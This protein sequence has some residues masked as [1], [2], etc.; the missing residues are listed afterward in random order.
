[1]R[2]LSIALALLFLFV[3]RGFGAD[4][5]ISA[6][7]EECLSCHATATPGIVSDWKRSRHA[8][9]TPSEAVRKPKLEKRM[10]VD[11]VPESV[12]SVTIGCAECH[13]ANY[14][15]HGDSFAHNGYAVHTVVTPR[16]CAVCH[17]VE[18]S[19]YGQNI[20][21]HAYGNL[22]NNPVYRE[23]AHTINAVVS[24]D[25]SGTTLGSPD[26]QTQEDSCLACHGTVVKMT[27]LRTVDTVQGEMELPVLAGWP[28]LGV[29]RI[30]P[31]G[32]AGACTPCHSRHQFSIELA[33]KPYACQKCHSGPDVPVNKVYSVSKHGNVFAGLNKDWNFQSVP[34]VLGKDFASPTCAVCHVSLTVNEDGEVLGERTHRMNDRKAWRLFGLIYAHPQ[35]KSPDTSTIRT[36]SGLPLPTE[37][38]GEPASGYLIDAAEQQKRRETMQK[39]CLGCHSSGWVA[40]HYKRLEHSIETTNELTKTA[41]KI[42]VKAWETGAAKGIAQKDSIFN[43]GI[44]K[45][46]S[47]QWLF[48]ANSARF[49][50]AMMGADYGV[51]ESGRW[52]MTKNIQ[53]LVD[54]LNVKSKSRNP[55]LESGK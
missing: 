29:G 22:M 6:A 3:G 21:S 13:T 53:Q 24:Y 46:W 30:N 38:T 2:N 39:V 28:N 15:E 7:T 12:Y 17:P 1:M 43:E 35:P 25:D 47:A 36:E 9:V 20:M 45:D 40:G 5:D 51:F 27:G 26:P 18:E 41:T 10:S 54:W 31:D 11:T 34:W 33:R 19:Q 55:S 44:E 14:L 4:K 50:S 8:R 42:I 49:A 52:F 32:S 37:F 23:L 16:D 48:Y